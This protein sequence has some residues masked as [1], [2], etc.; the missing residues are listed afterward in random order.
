MMSFFDDTE[1]GPNDTFIGWARSTNSGGAWVDQGPL[2]PQTTDLAILANAAVASD[3]AGRFYVAHADTTSNFFSVRVSR[4]TD[5]FPTFLP[6]VI[7]EEGG[8][9][10]TD[11]DHDKPWIAVDRRTS[12]NCPNGTP[13][14]GRI[15]ACWAQFDDPNDGDGI[16]SSRI[17]FAYSSNQGPSYTKPA[18]ST[19]L[20][21][22]TETGE[23]DVNGCSIAVGPQGHVFVGWHTYFGAKIEV[24]MSTDGGATFSPKVEVGTAR[25]PTTFASCFGG[26]PDTEVLNGNLREKTF[27]HLA[28]DVQDAT[29][30]YAAWNDFE[31]TGSNKSEIRFR[32]GAISGGTVN[33]LAN[34]TVTVNSVSTGD[35]FY[36]EISARLACLSNCLP[37]VKVLWLDRR[38]DVNNLA[39]HVYGDTSFDGGA[40][41]QGDEKWTDPVQ[42]LPPVVGVDPLVGDVCYF[43]DYLALT[44]TTTFIAGWP[45][46]RNTTTRPDVIASV[47]C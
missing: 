2:L 3:S 6:P 26:P 1:Y 21:G 36:P 19:N 46:T 34:P 15:Y 41:W 44:P 45:D 24:R 27:A 5:T 16:D 30:V 7:V 18:A 37:E 11:D 39:Y 40:T 9:S 23:G 31:P 35:Q 17:R 29:K 20:T 22:Y 38:D 33:F 47:G 14:A 12:G 4:S 28:A 8:P 43:G 42:P 10:G 32:R 13:C 25:V